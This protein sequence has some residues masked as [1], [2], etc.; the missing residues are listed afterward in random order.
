M[1][2]RPEYSRIARIGAAS[3]GLRLQMGFGAID[4]LRRVVDETFVLLLD[5]TDTAVGGTA[6]G[7]AGQCGA[8]D[9][10][11]QG[12]ASREPSDATAD[13]G[14]AE[15]TREDEPGNQP[16]DSADTVEMVFRAENGA[17]EMHAVRSV[18]SPISEAA[19]HRFDAF[20]AGL[21][22]D[23]DIDAARR[24]LRIRRKVEHPG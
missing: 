14:D 17:L 5:G 13:K 10:R 23:C 19:V 16:N 24:S 9:R 12:P 18:G 4:D 15:G 11:D 3:L 6:H 8:E 7:A 2:A 20:V 1:P 21:V 22:D